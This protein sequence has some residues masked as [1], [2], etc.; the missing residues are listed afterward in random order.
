MIRRKVVKILGS[1]NKEGR[2]GKF[3][4]ANQKVTEGGKGSA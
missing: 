3:Y 1:H 2:H 4:R